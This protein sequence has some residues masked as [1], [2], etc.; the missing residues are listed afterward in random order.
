MF[1]SNPTFIEQRYCSSHNLRIISS[2][3]SCCDLSLCLSLYKNIDLLSNTKLWIV[4]NEWKN[5]F[6]PTMTSIW[7][8]GQKIPSHLNFEHFLKEPF[9]NNIL[10]QTVLFQMNDQKDSLLQ[11]LGLIIT[12][13]RKDVFSGY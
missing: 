13:N 10:Q 4:R 11:E 12:A 8:C 3:L 6:R 9:K 5:N 7:Y 2:M 1:Y